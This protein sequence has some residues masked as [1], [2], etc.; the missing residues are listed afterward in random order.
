MC[1]HNSLQ[2]L[3]LLSDYLYVSADVIHKTGQC[4]IGFST[5]KS[6]HTHH[7]SSHGLFLK[8]EYMLNKA[9]CLGFFPIV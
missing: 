4:N 9:T 5:N 3:R 1:R 8:P 2:Q 6:Y 7:K